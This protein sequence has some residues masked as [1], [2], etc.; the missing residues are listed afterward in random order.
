MYRIREYNPHSGDLKNDYITTDEWKAQY[1]DAWSNRIVT[2][3]G[4][5]E[6]S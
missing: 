1:E 2:I 6:V 4:R 3:V 5:R